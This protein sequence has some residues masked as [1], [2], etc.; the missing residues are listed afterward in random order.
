M[1]GIDQQV[2]QVA[3]AYRNNPQQL[4]QKYAA[5]QELIDLLALQRLKSD[6][7]AAARQIQSQ[8][9]NN[10]ATIKQ[11]LEQQLAQETKQEMIGRVAPTLERKM[12]E[13]QQ[14][15]QQAPQMAEQAQQGIAALQQPQ[16][17][18]QQFN[19]GGIVQYFN[20]GGLPGERRRERRVS[21][22]PRA[23]IIDYAPDE[24]IEQ[25]RALGI[26]V[27]DYVA[28]EVAERMLEE[29]K[30]GGAVPQAASQ[31][32]SL[33]EPP[34]SSEEEE[35]VL[36]DV[37]APAQ[38][39]ETE[40]P[41]KGI[42]QAGA[43][44]NTGLP[45]TDFS[46]V[47]S[48]MQQ[49]VE[50]DYEM[51][52]IATVD[53]DEAA[54]YGRDYVDQMGGKMQSDQEISDATEAY[55]TKTESDMGLQDLINT[56]DPIIAERKERYNAIRDKDAQNRRAL[57]AFFRGF[58]NTT[59]I[60]T[61]FAAAS[62]SMANE[63][64]Q[65]HKEEADAFDAYEEIVTDTN[66]D[67]RDI[68]LAA[69]NAAAKTRQSLMSE[70]NNLRDIMSNK[71]TVNAQGQMSEN[72]AVNEREIEKYRQAAN[73]I[74]EQLKLAIDKT[75]IRSKEDMLSYS[76]DTKNIDALVKVLE[77]AKSRRLELVS[78]ALSD[79]MVAAS[80]RKAEQEGDTALAESLRDSA[81]ENALAIDASSGMKEFTDMLLTLLASRIKGEI[82]ES[83]RQAMG[84]PKQ[85]NNTDAA[86][87]LNEVDEA[88]RAYY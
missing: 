7:E 73:K 4:E 77:T 75:Q 63:V 15:M 10:P 81:T 78:A 31:T 68:R 80:I 65:L 1:A 57:S 18:Q 88:S 49:Y 38:D 61:G 56:T 86:R 85:G 82:P 79:P 83:I 55:R 87:D 58:A 40:I 23:S 69:I 59:N 76:N 53:Y 3:D 14:R 64:S 34:V 62:Q 16:Q 66:S 74:K 13:Q 11:Q 72:R 21:P 8:M 48:L 52:P 22:G 45:T 37:R 29:A 70:R 5:S 6:K 17:P 51:A 41:S 47:D 71:A 25:L 12:Q 60:G 33:P 36:A 84:R 27:P 26:D 46:E 19:S 42:T 32:D 67:K 35:T 20:E 30:A 39:V 50:N 24:T 54:Q 9:Q 44:S 2:G 43:S 28:P